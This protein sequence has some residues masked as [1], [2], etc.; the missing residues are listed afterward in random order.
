MQNLELLAGVSG[1]ACV[2]DPQVEEVDID[3]VAARQLLQP[4]SVSSPLFFARLLQ[5]PSFISLG[6]S[7]CNTIDIT[8]NNDSGDSRQ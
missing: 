7:Y 5:S 6:D 1:A 4:G 3:E 8:Y 2:H